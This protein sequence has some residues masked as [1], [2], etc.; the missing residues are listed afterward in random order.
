VFA[1]TTLKQDFCFK[2]R[3]NYV[4][5]AS[6]YFAEKVKDIGGSERMNFCRSNTNEYLL[7][8]LSK[9]THLGIVVQ[10]REHFEAK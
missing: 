3:E 5:F 4:L 6:N 1:S 7:L 10:V 9:I 8:L 2:E